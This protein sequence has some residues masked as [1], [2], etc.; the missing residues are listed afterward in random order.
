VLTIFLD[1]AFKP[2]EDFFK[3]SLSNLFN[4]PT[5]DEQ[6]KKGQAAL[7]AQLAHVKSIDTKVSAIASQTPQAGAAAAG[8]AT[9][10]PT[11]GPVPLAVVPFGGA[12]TDAMWDA[13]IFPDLS[14]QFESLAIA[15]DGLSASMGDTVDLFSGAQANLGTVFSQS[16][17]TIAEASNQGQLANNNFKKALGQT[18]QGIGMAAG[19]IMGI[20]AGVGQIKKGGTSNT[21]AGIGGILS[22]IGGIAGGFAGLFGGGGGGGV[23]SFSGAFGSSGPSFNPGVFSMP[24]LFA[25]GGIVNGPTLGLVGEGKYNEAIVPLP[26]GKSIPVQMQ[27]ENIRD[28]MSGSA[29]GYSVPSSLNFSFETTNINGTEYV[30]REQL[31]MAMMETRKLASREGAQRGANLAIDKLQQSPN[32]R[33]RVGIR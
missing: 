28:K 8:T 25:N 19:A 11:S 5:E 27:G 2:V 10:A 30:S 15:S 29:G 3:D 6:R 18:V 32:I 21:L 1:Y 14:E 26:N 33:R 16:S 13:S 24:K 17:A 22:T 31:E 9:A 4:V 7:E 12:Q 23:G 20:A